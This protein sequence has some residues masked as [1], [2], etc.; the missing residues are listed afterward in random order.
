MRLV[1]LEIQDE[2]LERFEQL[3]KRM[4]KTDMKEVLNTAL[5]V[6][7]WVVDELHEGRTVGAIDKDGEGYHELI[8][9]GLTD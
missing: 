3:K 1:Q 9:P 4:G 5:T 8:L 2:A 7:N 6:L